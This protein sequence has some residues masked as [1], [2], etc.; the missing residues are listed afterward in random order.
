MLKQNVDTLL[1]NFWRIGCTSF[2]L[3]FLDIWVGAWLVRYIVDNQ[4]EDDVKPIGF[5]RNM[6]VS[7]TEFVAWYE[8]FLVHYTICMYI[9]Y[10]TGPVFS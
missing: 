2:F 9:L 3:W 7:D 6:E 5:H 8:T 1:L 4:F 10:F